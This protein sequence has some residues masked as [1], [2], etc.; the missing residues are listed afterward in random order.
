MIALVMM[1]FPEV[2]IAGQV[3][4]TVS[5]QPPKITEVDGFHHISVPNAI[6]SGESGAPALPTDCV[7]MLLPPGE[8]AVSVE[9]RGELWRTLP[10]TYRLE[11]ISEQRRLSDTSPWKMTPPDPKIYK[12]VDSFPSEPVSNLITHLK[13]GYALATCLV[14]PVRWNPVNGS[15][16][17]LA[18]AE[19]IVETSP[20]EREQTGYNHFFR[21]D[22]KTCDWVADKVRNLQMLGTYPR[23]DDDIPEAILIVT[24]ETLQRTAEDYAAWWSARGRMTYIA[25]VEDLVENENGDDDQERIRN[26]IIEYYDDL[27]I[28]YLILMGDTE[29][30]PH[31]GLWGDVNDSP[32]YDIPADLYYAALD[33][34]WNNDND[35]SWGEDNESDLT[36]EVAVGRIPGVMNRE[37]ERL[38][39]K[40]QLYSDEPV[41]ENILTALMLGENLGWQ[42]MGGEYMD[43]IYE[44]CDR[45]NHTTVGFPERFNRRN[46]YDVYNGWE[47]SGTGDLAPLISEGYHM[48]HHLG[49]AY[50]NT[51][52]KLNVNQVTNNLI[53][54]DG[55]DEGFNIAQSQGCYAG[56]FDNRSTEPGQYLNTDCIG[57]M[58]VSGIDNGFV[59]FICNSRYGW[60]SYNNTNGA[61]QHFHREFVDAIFS[62]DITI[63]GETHQD[64]KED[65]AG[66]V[67]GNGG[68]RWCYY[69]LNLLGDPA[70][71]MWT[72]EPE[73][74]DPEHTGIIVLGSE[75]YEVTVEGFEGATVCISH[76][77]EILAVCLTDEDGLAHLEFENPL[78]EEANLT[79]TITAHNYLMYSAEIRTI[80]PEG[81]YP[82]V[83]DMLIDDSEGNGN[84][85]I[86]AGE[87]IT[88]NPFVRNLG[89]ETLEEL[90]ITIEIN[91][92]MITII[93]NTAVYPDIEAAAETFADEGLVLSIASHC[94][95]LREVTM[96]CE[97]E[98]N[99]DE[100]WAQEITFIVHSPVFVSHFLSVLESEGGANGV[101]NPGGEAEMLLMLTNSG[102]GDAA[103]L[104]AVLDCDNP[105]VE[106]VETEASL[107]SLNANETD[108]FVQAFSVRISEDCPDLY[109][110][111]FYIR[112]SGENGYYRTILEEIGIGGAYYTFERD[113]E[114]WNHYNIGEN[115]GDQWNLFDGANCTP[116]GTNCIKLGTD[117]DNQ[118]YNNN[119]NCAIEMPEFHVTESMLLFFYHK[120]DAENST[121]HEGQAYDG[122]FVEISVDG[123]DWALLYP[124]VPEEP[125]YPYEI[126]HGSENPF[127]LGQ[128]VWSGEIDEWT[129]VLF[130]LEDYAGE[131]VV[132]RFHFGSDGSTEGT[133]WWIDDIQLRLKTEKEYPL[134]LE[135]EIRG[136]GAYL[137]WSTPSY[138]QRDEDIYPNELLGYRIYRGLDMLDT[139]VT[140]NRFFDNMVGLPRGDYSYVIT[141]EY[142]NGESYPSNMVHLFWPAAVDEDAENATPTEWS[143]TEL[144]P[145][146]FN[147]LARISYSIPA[148]GQ[149]RLAVYD[150]VG[151]EID[152]LANGSCQPGNYQVIFNAET[153]PSGIYIVRLQTPVGAKASRLVLI[154]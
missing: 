76:E 60:G 103:D 6:V 104:T 115:W 98:N 106:L 119:L 105:Y 36:A 148:A 47:W 7:W 31:R 48:I 96:D 75:D 114:V 37:I 42:I 141:A 17:Y 64:S 44:G 81:G 86:D 52:L 102:T 95:D 117:N 93:N 127:E 14:S 126:I 78:N 43:E 88:L 29:Q 68:I 154:R 65:L 125:A 153:L 137:N 35:R 92:P 110:A 129:P 132:V 21:G 50:T 107:A 1:I 55:V 66:W 80:Q 22:R 10:G 134:D 79:L 39:H 100:T 11:P 133:G 9:L 149:I 97:I 142:N 139:L 152:E 83:I 136:A 32:D 41:I 112:I 90:T 4:T 89:Q 59:A 124:E 26:G 33:G 69:E 3:S 145:N 123:G 150:L 128:K 45:Y 73:E 61:S 144:Y 74:F 147:A 24:N 46:L 135:G 109:R 77:G 51:C 85:L 113:Y 38:T 87:T 108:Y 72:D 111:V 120:I 62:E 34:N 57:E 101:L 28:G 130:D 151:R 15:L 20:G 2:V 8:R 23:R 40:V 146:P 53:R 143:L 58:L 13:R 27:D 30:V 131:N 122:G 19:L 5:Y 99:A 71:D 91:D 12:G 116:D 84:G 138:P 25:T 140:D 121:R 118:D 67:R 56:A 63:I 16:Q 70:M 82:W 54:N 18:Q 94:P 49:H